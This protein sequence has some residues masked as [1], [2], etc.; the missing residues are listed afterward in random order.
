MPFSNHPSPMFLAGRRLAQS[1]LSFSSTAG[2]IS[3]FF[4]F[5]SMPSR[6]WIVAPLVITTSCPATSSMSTLRNST[7]QM[8]MPSRTANL[9]PGHRRGPAEKGV[10]LY[11]VFSSFGCP[12]ASGPNRIG[13]KLCELGPQLAGARCR[14]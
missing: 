3:R 1:T 9:S 13:S 12:S 6:V 14:L 10:Y 11:P 5:T 2:T 8:A 4:A 7:A